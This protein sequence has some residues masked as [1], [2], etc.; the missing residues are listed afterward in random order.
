M[1]T[2]ALTGIS[3]YCISELTNNHVKTLN[4]KNFCNI[5]ALN[6]LRVND[7]IFITS[8]SK[9]DLISGTDGI[10]AQVKKLGIHIQKENPCCSEETEFLVGRVQVEFIGYASCITIVEDEVLYPSVIRVK[11]KSMYDY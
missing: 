1:K 8:M 3:P 6:S 9:D 11:L 10:V 2:V 5:M 4:L 7:F